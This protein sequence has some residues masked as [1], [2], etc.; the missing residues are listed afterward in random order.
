MSFTQK[1]IRQKND[2]P[3]TELMARHEY[4]WSFDS[5]FVHT[6]GPYF[7]HFGQVIW[8]GVWIFQRPFSV[9]RSFIAWAFAGVTGYI[10]IGIG[11][12]I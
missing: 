10:I 3:K 11:G 9:S 1:G 8:S 4:H 2:G 12:I 7:W 6:V 5:Y